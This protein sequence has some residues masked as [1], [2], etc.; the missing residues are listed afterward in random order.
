[1]SNVSNRHVVNQFIAGT[2][3]PLA[4]QR[5]AK[6]GYKTTTDKK[7]KKEIPPKFPSVCASVPKFSNAQILERSGDL[8]DSIRAVVE[9]AQDG[10]FKSLY[11][12]SG[13][14]LRE[15]ADQDISI[16]ACIAF[17]AAESE[18]DRLTKESIGKWF[19]SSLQDNLIVVRA[20]LYGFAELNEE[21][22]KRVMQD[23]NA[24]KG[25]LQL[26]AGK[27]VFLSETQKSYIA[28]AL[29]YAAE[30][31]AVAQKLIAK[32]EK[33]NEAIDPAAALGFALS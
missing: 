32:F 2:S 7:T 21:Q 18:G 22:L 17:L 26:L 15:V 30:D 19:V 24:F 25:L 16:D 20:D 8:V 14:T 13:G 3:K 6:V 9:S 12:S 31:D 5:L 33:L 23:C 4:E 11:E 10:I 27:D 1:M 28:Y 29:K